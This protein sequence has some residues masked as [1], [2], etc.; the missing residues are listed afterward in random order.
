M[1]SVTGQTELGFMFQTNEQSFTLSLK[2]Y[3]IQLLPTQGSWPYV[4]VKYSVAQNFVGLSSIYVRLR[5]GLADIYNHKIRVSH[6][7]T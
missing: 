2:P 1:I 5:T 4:G 3:L 7:M 6:F